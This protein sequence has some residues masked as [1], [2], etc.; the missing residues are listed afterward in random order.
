VV[1]VYVLTGSHSSV[2]TPS[3]CFELPFLILIWGRWAGTLTRNSGTWGCFLSFTDAENKAVSFR[4][5]QALKLLPWPSDWGH[6]TL[7]FQK[8]YYM[9]WPLAQIAQADSYSSLGTAVWVPWSLV[10][11]ASPDPTA[12]P[13]HPLTKPSGLV[14]FHL[15]SGSWFLIYCSIL[16]KQAIPSLPLQIVMARQLF[17]FL[18]FIFPK[19]C[20]S[21]LCYHWEPKLQNT[22]RTGLPVIPCKTKNDSS[23]SLCLCL[24]I[25]AMGFGGT[26]G[27]S[28]T[29]VSSANHWGSPGCAFINLWHLE[30][31]WICT[32]FL[33]KAIQRLN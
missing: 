28:W 24:L 11:I 27:E 7:N 2:G 23:Q 20:C 21:H 8:V 9:V 5:K 1:C 10:S 31:T 19:C 30:T 4:E 6:R 14:T 22:L 13:R 15:S 29:W 12:G 32:I 33:L 16:S 25:S 3:S 18:C 26:S 17:E